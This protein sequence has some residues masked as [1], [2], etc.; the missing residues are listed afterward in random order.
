MPCNSQYSL[1]KD[2]DYHH[3]FYWLIKTLLLVLYCVVWLDFDLC[4]WLLLYIIST[5]KVDKEFMHLL[6]YYDVFEWIILS[7]T[8]ILKTYFV[9]DLFRYTTSLEFIFHPTHH[10]YQHNNDWL[11]RQHTV[12]W[13]NIAFHYYYHY[14]CLFYIQ[15]SFILKASKNSLHN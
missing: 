6:P 7:F 14:Y 10:W 9:K 4:I 15:V 5:Y 12:S 8:L 13:A 3:S 11:S 1:H 2:T